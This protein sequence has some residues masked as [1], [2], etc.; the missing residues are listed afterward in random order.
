MSFDG[1][2]NVSISDTAHALNVLSRPSERKPKSNFPL[3]V[4][5][6]FILLMVAL[7]AFA[8]YQCASHITVGMNTLRTQEITDNAYVSLDLYIFREETVISSDAR[9][10][11][12]LYSVSDGEYVGR[13]A[14]GNPKP[15]QCVLCKAADTQSKRHANA[16][17]SSKHAF[18]DRQKLR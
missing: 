18:G 13:S 4:R 1:Q 11:L 5:L 6:G 3:W 10:A 16:C 7:I 8:I 17:G 15:A 12:L 9:G 2:K 14:Q